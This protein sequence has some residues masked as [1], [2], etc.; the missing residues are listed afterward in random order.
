[1]GTTEVFTS[2]KMQ[3]EHESLHSKVLMVIWAPLEPSQV[4]NPSTDSAYWVVSYITSH[5]L[6]YISCF[7]SCVRHTYSL[8]VM[9]TSNFC[10]YLAFLRLQ[11]VKDMD[12]FQFVPFSS[13]LYLLFSISGQASSYLS[14]VQTYWQQL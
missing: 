5:Q 4:A 9:A 12:M 6:S 11:A 2:L 3:K 14:S 1:M 13:N 8:M 7:K 10:N